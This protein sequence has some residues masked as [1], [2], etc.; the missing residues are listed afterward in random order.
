MAEQLTTE[1]GAEE[2]L[3]PK[4]KPSVHYLTSDAFDGAAGLMATE[5]QRRKLV[6]RLFPEGEY[7][8]HEEESILW[9]WINAHADRY[10]DGDY[11]S[12]RRMVNDAADPIFG[13]KGY[14]EISKFIWVIA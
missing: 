3:P 14:R 12:A 11:N 2:L 13:G 10:F 1:G 6:R 9:N 4:D 5:E 7:E 8:W